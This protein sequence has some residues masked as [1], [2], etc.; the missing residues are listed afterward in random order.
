MF[1]VFQ[2]DA[3]AEAN[4]TVDCRDGKSR[5]FTAG[6]PNGSESGSYLNTFSMVAWVQPTADIALPSQSTSGTSG[7]TDNRNDVVYPPPAHD[8]FGW[9]YAGTGLSVGRNG[10][11][12]CMNTAPTILRRSLVYSGAIAGWTHIAVI[13][14]EG[15][16]SLYVNGHWV[17]NGVK[18]PVQVHSGIGWPCPRPAAALSR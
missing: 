2:Q 7:V 14:R 6:R 8:V 18:G 17:K 5:L 4:R 16:P 13:Y 11:C 1:V 3:K 12:V 15:V 9:S 10:A